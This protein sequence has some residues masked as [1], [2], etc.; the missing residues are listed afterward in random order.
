MIYHHREFQSR[1]RDV[2]RLWLY[3]QSIVSDHKALSASLAEA[4]SSSRRWESEAK[5][6]IEKVARTKGEKNVV[7]HDSSMAR[8][9][10][11]A[12]GSAMAK[13]E[14]ELSR[15]QNALAVAQEARRKAEDEASRLAAKRVSLLLKLGT[16][17]DEMS[18]LQA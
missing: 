7:R 16:N 10:V 6:S 14:F 3:A 12:T 4:E 13:V 9:N 15:A 1:L 18:T 17:K 5:E 2:E 8:M 11:D